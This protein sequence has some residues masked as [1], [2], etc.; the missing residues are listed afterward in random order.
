MQARRHRPV[1][2]PQDPIGFANQARL[3]LAPLINGRTVA[4]FTMH[5]AHCVDMTEQRF[6]GIA[7]C[8]GVAVKH[9]ASNGPNKNTIS[10]LRFSRLRRQL[11]AM[12]FVTVTVNVKLFHIVKS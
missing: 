1:T 8:P 2:F 4:D 5:A 11:G 7:L 9:A 12:R 6:N 3:M 10:H